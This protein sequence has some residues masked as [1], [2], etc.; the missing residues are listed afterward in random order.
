MRI[1]RDIDKPSPPS[2]RDGYGGSQPSGV[3]KGSGSNVAKGYGNVYQGE[4][5]GGRV[6]ISHHRSWSVAQGSA[7][8][9]MAELR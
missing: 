2:C 3:V 5:L 1:C 8:A 6:P 9:P 7:L 4:V